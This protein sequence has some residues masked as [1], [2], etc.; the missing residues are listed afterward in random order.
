MPHKKAPRVYYLKWIWPD[1]IDAFGTRHVGPLGKCLMCDEV[2]YSMYG[3]SYICLR[4]A[5][6]L[7]DGTEYP[8]ECPF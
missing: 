2:T 8:A 7:T 4:H 3:E 1:T 5:L 6:W